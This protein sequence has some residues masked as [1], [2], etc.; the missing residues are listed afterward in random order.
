MKIITIIKKGK[1]QKKNYQFRSEMCFFF[2]PHF[3]LFNIPF[4]H[5]S[6]LPY[7]LK[8]TCKTSERKEEIKP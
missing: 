7:N 1:K 6:D 2:F 4:P 3:F 5:F 8:I